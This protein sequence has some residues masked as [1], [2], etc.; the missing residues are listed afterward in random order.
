MKPEE[1]KR[2][3]L[4]HRPGCGDANDPEMVEALDFAQRDPE[5]R[6]WLERHLAFQS[7]MRARFGALPVPADLKAAILKGKVVDFPRW[8]QHP[9]WLAAAA[10]LA[11]LIG[12]AAVCLQRLPAGERFAFYRAHIATSGLREYRSEERRVGKEYRWWRSRS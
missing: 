4:L 9:A 5:L 7:A 6:Q 1:A 12:I 2:I 11:V 8:W 3:L 10:A